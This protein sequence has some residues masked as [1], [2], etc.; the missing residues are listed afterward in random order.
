MRKAMSKIGIA[1]F[2]RNNNYGA[3][4]QAYA[5]QNIIELMGFESEIINYTPVDHRKKTFFS[6]LTTLLTRIISKPSYIFDLYK[7]RKYINPAK[8]KLF[9]L[10]RTDYLKISPTVLSLSKLDN[11]KSSFDACVCGSDQIWNPQIA[12]IDPIFF[13]SFM[14][15]KQRIAYAPSFGIT[16]LSEHHFN[17]IQDLVSKFSSLSCREA[18]GAKLIS[19][20]T[21]K[22]CEVVLD[23]TLLLDN[24]DWEKIST[25]PNHSIPARY[26]L[27][28]LVRDDTDAKRIAELIAADNNIPLL[29]IPPVTSGFNCKIACLETIGPR[30]F[31]F[32]ISHAAG[33]ISDSF[34]GTAFALNFGKPFVSLGILPVTHPQNRQS[35][36][37][38]LLEIVDLR[39]RFIEKPFYKANNIFAFDSSISQEILASE[40]IKSKSYLYNALQLSTNVKIEQ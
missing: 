35:R 38:S 16:S 30:E 19:T 33:V 18:E 11:I 17:A 3:V 36:I 8:A 5:L 12:E 26:L 2:F 39:S 7:A 28:Y 13:L 24:S 34:H 22:S 15:P 27:C 1:T 23:P 25:P 6:R 9:D 4:L 20:M 40:R 14:P 21:G 10:F 29:V 31:I 37:V 32:L